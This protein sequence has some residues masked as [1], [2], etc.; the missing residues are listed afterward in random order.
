MNNLSEFLRLIKEFGLFKVTLAL[1]FLSA[2]YWVPYYMVN[3]KIS[4][5]QKDVSSIS[6]NV[7]SIKN[8]IN[9]YPSTNQAETG[10]VV[11]GSNDESKQDINTNFNPKDWIIDD[12]FTLRA[13]G[14]YCRPK[15]KKNSLLPIWSIWTSEFYDIT[16]PFEVTLKIDGSGDSENPPTVSLMSGK[17]IPK[18]SPELNFRLSI[19]D[20]DNQ[21]IRLYGSE[22]M[23]DR[24][25][26]EPDLS[27]NITIAVKPTRLRDSDRRIYLNPSIK[28]AVSGTTDSMT[29]PVKDFST[30]IQS[31]DA[32]VKYQYGI[33]IRE[34]EC[35]K[36]ESK[37]P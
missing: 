37:N 15:L 23:S 4:S 21:S 26:S 35:V 12:K 17:Y 31:V 10:G 11:Q 29:Y 7:N 8:T 6:T 32:N 2:M 28:Y 27:S 24:L 1:M 33:G 13:D 34:G 19:F 30:V 25:T 22:N 3:T 36:I 20:T 16:T 5:L 9:V 14:Y 18:F